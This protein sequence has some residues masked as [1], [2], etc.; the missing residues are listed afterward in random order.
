MLER[1]E[2]LALDS[3][4][5]VKLEALN[6]AFL[7]RA[8]SATAPLVD[9][10]VARKGKVTDAVISRRLADIAPGMRQILVSTTGQVSE[11]LTDEQRAKLPPWFFSAGTMV[12][13]GRGTGGGRGNPPSGGRRQ[14][15]PGSSN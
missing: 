12:G 13:P 15:G 4:Q 1:R 6:A 10:L 5:I 8:D 9:Y 3:T 14:R 2:A 11:M 7:M